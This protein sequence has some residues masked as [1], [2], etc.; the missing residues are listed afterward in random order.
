MCPVYVVPEGM[1]EWHLLQALQKPFGFKIKN[2]IKPKEL[3]RENLLSKDLLSAIKSSGESHVLALLDL[4]AEAI[5]DLWNRIKSV[6]SETDFKDL[7]DS[8][9]KGGLVQSDPTGKVLGIWIMPD[10][11]SPG[12][13]E[14]FFLRNIPMDDR[15]LDQTVRFVQQLEP[16]RFPATQVAEDKAKLGVWCSIQEEAGPPGRPVSNPECKFVARS[17]EWV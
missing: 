3:G 9:P 5:D 4:E 14:A 7:P 6:L 11:S 13:I 10:N 17:R 16:R 2:F 12:A 8:F 1:V 15:L